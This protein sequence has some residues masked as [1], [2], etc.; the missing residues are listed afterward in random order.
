MNKATAYP[1]EAQPPT[2]ED[3]VNAYAL[4]IKRTALYF[5]STMPWADLDDLIQWGVVGLLEAL[6]RFDPSRG[7]PFSAFANRRIR[8]AMLDSLRREGRE[9]SRTTREPDHVAE[10]TLGQPAGFKDPAEILIAESDESALA[11]YIEALPP[12]QKFVLQLLY[13]EGHNNREIAQA[14]DVSEAYISKTRRQAIE[15]IAEMRRD[16]DTGGKS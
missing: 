11:A 12:R 8:G 13:V 3:A 4:W 14:L 7:K 5:R 15:R 9:I 6:E 1:L 10:K 16:T 2:P